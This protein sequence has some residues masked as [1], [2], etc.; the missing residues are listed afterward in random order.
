MQEDERPSQPMAMRRVTPQ[1][2]EQAL[3]D[4]A[5]AKRAA[6]GAPARR[7][8][9]GRRRRCDARCSTHRRGRGRCGDGGVTARSPRRGTPAPGLRRSRSGR[10]RGGSG[11]AAPRPTG[12]GAPP[13]RRERLRANP[14]GG[15]RGRALGG[16]CLDGRLRNG[17]ARLG[18]VRES[19]RGGRPGH[20]QAV[21]TNGSYGAGRYGLGSV[22]VARPAGRRADGQ[23]ALVAEAAPQRRQTAAQGPEG[24]RSPRLR[25]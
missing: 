7:R 11:R 15:L 13:P 9:L 24:K 25:R 20:V 18:D 17:R 5:A 3:E 6:G 8:D 21:G 22:L 12:R 23:V 19:R 14:G 16:R 1:G 2:A 4:V 10:G